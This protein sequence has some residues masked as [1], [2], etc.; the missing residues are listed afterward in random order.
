MKIVHAADLHLDSPLRGL[1]RY[2]GA[3][4]DEIRGATRRAL[5]NLVGL[6]LE[7]DARL[8]L[9]AGDLFDGEWD[10]YSTGLFFAGQMAR[11]REAGVPVV[12]V[13][14]N[15]D[16]AS[17]VVQAI[18]ACPTTCMSSPTSGPRALLSTSSGWPCTGRASRAARSTRICSKA[19]PPPREGL[20]NIGLLHT[21]AGGREGHD[22]Y[23]P[24]RV[25]DLVGK[26]YD[27]WALGHVH[28]REVLSSDPWV[29]FPGN[30]QG[31]HIRETGAKGATL[32]EIES[33]RILSVEHR[34]LDVVRW[35]LCHVDA[36]DAANADD[37]LDLARAGVERELAEAE[38][39]TLAVARRDCR[40]DPR[41]RPARRRA[42]ALGQQRAARLPRSWLRD[43][44]WVE[45]VRLRTRDDIDLAAL[46]ERD[47]AV[48]QLLASLASLRGSES[49]LGML[50]DELA[51]LRRKLPAS[52]AKVAAA[53]VWTS[54]SGCASC[55]PTWSSSYCRGCC[56]GRSTSR[57]IPFAR[58]DGVRPVHR[59]RYRSVVG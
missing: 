59:P 12:W 38:G 17:R 30:L 50:A 49:G 40:Y 13:R 39:R 36:S 34:V 10:D 20:I 7:E 14:G 31:R 26:G 23:A 16:A 53:C 5:E 43:Y 56:R 37:V 8:L 11:L 57:A 51:E 1:E 15:H 24:C 46:A 41:P 54:P 48:G 21:S 27:Y 4:V 22:V 25:E 2:Q 19:Y 28:Q 45:K 9:I 55:S 18:G 52:S 29:V 47:D 32:I 6:C 58:P 3:P 35:A 33:E 44:V 42:R